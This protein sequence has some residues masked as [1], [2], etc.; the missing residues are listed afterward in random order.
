MT[1]TTQSAARAVS[2]DP[3]DIYVIGL[4]MVAI[5]QLTNEAEAAIDKSQVLFT[6]DYHTEMLERYVGDRVDELVDLTEEY[7]E[8]E[9]RIETYERMA[10]RVIDRAGEIDG[11]V[12]FALYGH[13]LVFVT[14]SQW[15]TERATEAGLRVEVQPGISSMDC[16]YCDLGLDPS[17]NG[18]QMFE[19]TDLLLREFELN[20]N[21]PAMIWQVG[22]VEAV[23]Y[24]ERTGNE[25][26]RF[27]RLREYLERFYPPDH[28]V[29]IVQTATYPIT[30]SKL[31]RFELQAF[32][33][34]ADEINPIQT[35]YV[36]PVAEKSVQNRE[37]Q[38]TIESA[39]HLEF[40]TR[41]E[42]PAEA[43]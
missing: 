12:A 24:S 13:P 19:A 29:T 39:E 36:P 22:S 5:R 7:T 3:V 17:R 26:A 15:V 38:E 11:P 31:L 14:P 43:R 1:P 18:I 32:E 6:V 37:L 2:D 35:L 21:V 16:L 10:Q 33:S 28:E 34:M 40:I 23:Q 41:D 9:H 4:G 8:G 20:S 27:T 30:D 25:P 42:D